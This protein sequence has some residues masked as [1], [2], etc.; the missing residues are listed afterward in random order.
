MR[1]LPQKQKAYQIR[2]KEELN[3]RRLRSKAKRKETRLRQIAGE[4]T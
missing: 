4:E 2:R 3:K 1:K